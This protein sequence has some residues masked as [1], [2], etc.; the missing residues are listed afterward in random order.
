MKN[1]P[2]KKQTALATWKEIEVAATSILKQLDGVI[3]GK[4]IE[5]KD[6]LLKVR[7]YFHQP[8]HRNVL[9]CET[10]HACCQEKLHRTKQGVNKMLAEGN[11]SEGGNKVSAPKR[12]PTKL[13]SPIVFDQWVTKTIG[14][15]SQFDLEMQKKTWAEF[16]HQVESGLGWIDATPSSEE[17]NGK[18]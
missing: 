18:G 7:D 1:Q 4:L 17:S 11:K 2:T 13:S 9:G 3:C 16:K 8:E 5:L 15:F 10:W 14:Y 6:D 12:E